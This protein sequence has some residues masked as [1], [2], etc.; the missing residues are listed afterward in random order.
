MQKEYFIYTG[1]DYFD[2]PES[3]RPEII[4]VGVYETGT[5]RR[6]FLGFFDKYG[7]RVE[8]GLV[9]PGAYLYTAR[10]REGQLNRLPATRG[11][12]RNVLRRLVRHKI[13]NALKGL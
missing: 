3:E 8:G 4:P 5:K 7:Q 9:S 10:A 13:D 11:A 2:L 6:L 1:L 12:I